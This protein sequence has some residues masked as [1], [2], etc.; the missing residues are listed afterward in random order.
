METQTISTPRAKWGVRSNSPS[1]IA[2]TSRDV[3]LLAHLASLR[4]L[5]AEQLGKL[6]GGSE[7]NVTRCLRALFD[8]G[9]VDQVGDP[10]VRR[11]YA[12]TR[13]GAR[14]LKEYGHLVDPSVRWSLKNQRA[15]ARFIDHT[16]G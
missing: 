13:K 7:Q 10:F 11:A 5:T 9:Y 8:H 14:L 16:L 12:I 15:G 1:P 3:T 4:F 2:I 6:D